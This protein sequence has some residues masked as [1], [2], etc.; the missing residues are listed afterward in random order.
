MNVCVSA[1]VCVS[2]AFFFGF[3]FPAF[4]FGF[5]SFCPIL[6]CLFFYVISINNNITILGTCLC[7]NERERERCDFGW[8]GKWWGGPERS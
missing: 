7:S 5:V 1:H 2:C 6:V 3:F 8:V 4:L